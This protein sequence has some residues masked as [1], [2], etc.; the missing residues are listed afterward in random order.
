V[1]IGSAVPRY[2]PTGLAA[3]FKTTLGINDLMLRKKDDDFQELVQYCVDLRATTPEL[4][5]TICEYLLEECGGHT[6]P[7]L[8]FIE[9]FFTHADAKKFLEKE[10]EFHRYFIGP[11]FTRSLFYE[12]VRDRCFEQVLDPEN[13]QV[14]FRVLG[15]KE[16]TSDINTLLR[17]GWWNYET[18]GFISRFLVNACLNG[19]VS[20]MGSVLYLDKKNSPEENT[21]LVIVEG[22]SAMEDSDFKCSTDKS[23]VKVEDGVSFN[24]AYRARVKTSI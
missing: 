22:L 18:R 24:W 11:D 8:A 15:G 5:Q 7:T 3:R 4:T 10:T 13:E 9:H 21:E 20:K 14:A 16:E 6:F 19:V 23:N 17:L 1:T 2:F 12:S